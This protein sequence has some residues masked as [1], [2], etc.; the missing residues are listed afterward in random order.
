MIKKWKIFSQRQE[1]KIYKASSKHKLQQLQFTND[2]TKIQNIIFGKKF[3]FQMNFSPKQRTKRHVR[4]KQEKK[5]SE[6]CS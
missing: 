3:S 4:N 5:V 6:V 2:G 1:S